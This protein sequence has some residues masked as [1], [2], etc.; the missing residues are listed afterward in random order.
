MFS[1]S[2]RCNLREGTLLVQSS[3]LS[4]QLNLI[5]QLDDLRLCYLS[6]CGDRLYA[7]HGSSHVLLY[8]DNYK[9]INIVRQCAEPRMARLA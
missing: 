1:F 9:E 7:D 4:S 3:D 5:T 6:F 8:Q 2:P